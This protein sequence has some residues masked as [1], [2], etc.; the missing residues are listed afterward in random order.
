[1]NDC[2]AILILISKLWVR[3]VQ[4]ASRSTSNSNEDILV[5]I[6][7]LVRPHRLVLAS[8]SVPHLVVPSYIA[9]S[10][11]HR[12]PIPL[13][14]VNSVVVV[15]LL[16]VLVLPNRPYRSIFSN[17]SRSRQVLPARPLSP[18]T[19]VKSPVTRQTILC[20]ATM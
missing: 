1:M 4:S 17:S 14:S 2:E 3:S 6:L 10:I 7:V 19:L 13:L 18:A 16:V 9:N 15:P 11:H 5:L 8:Q 20:V 12:Q